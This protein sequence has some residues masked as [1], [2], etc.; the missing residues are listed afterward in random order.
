MLII[1]DKKS[2][3]L[4][5][6]FGLAEDPLYNNF[7]YKAIFHYSGMQWTNGVIWFSVES[8]NVKTVSQAIFDSNHDLLIP[9]IVSD[10][11]YGIWPNPCTLSDEFYKNGPRIVARIN[12]TPSNNPVFYFQ[13]CSKIIVNNK[14]HYSTKLLRTFDLIPYFWNKPQNDNANK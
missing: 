6:P 5:K 10:Q 1:R 7:N 2:G 9:L 12:G 13:L 4:Y 3:D 14:I 11:R 8:G